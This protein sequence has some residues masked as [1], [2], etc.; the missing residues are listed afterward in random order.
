[1]SMH[2]TTD[3]EIF[4]FEKDSFSNF[5]FYRVFMKDYKFYISRY[6]ITNTTI[7][8]DVLKTNKREV[9]DIVSRSIKINLE[10][11]KL[12]DKLLKNISKSSE[13]FL[14]KLISDDNYLSFINEGHYS[15]TFLSYHSEDSYTSNVISY[16][17]YLNKYSFYFKSN[18]HKGY[19]N[20]YVPN[21]PYQLEIE[22]P[23]NKINWEQEVILI[24]EKDYNLFL[25]C[26]VSYIYY[27]KELC[28][29]IE[30]ITKNKIEGA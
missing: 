14:N 19:D 29:S 27:W 9:T 13:S 6:E 2:N 5:I 22:I 30:K 23:V 15:Y 18:F 3:T 20:D 11:H 26:I 25:D 28:R 12:F 1:M 24:D 7:T 4:V 17:I 8:F 16:R 10:Y 21:P